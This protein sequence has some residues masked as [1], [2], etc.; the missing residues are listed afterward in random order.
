MNGPSNMPVCCCVVGSA[1]SQSSLTGRDRPGKAPQNQ[2]AWT[3]A[4][5]TAHASANRATSAVSV[6]LASSA[7][8]A[9]KKRST[10][11]LEYSPLPA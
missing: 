6:D 8:A 10:A 3:R 11:P 4:A 1:N 2:G 5:R 9:T 7:T